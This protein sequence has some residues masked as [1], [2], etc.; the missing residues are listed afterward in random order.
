MST[1]PNVAAQFRVVVGDTTLIGRLFDNATA[2]DFASQLPMTL[3]FSDLHGV[4]KGAKLPRKLSVDGMPAGD[5]PQ[6][7]DLGYWAPDGNLVLYY[8]DVGY[9]TGIMRVGHF[10]GDMRAIAAKSGDFDA[11]V[12]LVP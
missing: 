9:W 3:T 5:D 8:G 11:T 2:R 7:G 4:E 12:E 1:S 6:I 10:D